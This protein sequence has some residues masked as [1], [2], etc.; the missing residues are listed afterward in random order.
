MRSPV[1][2]RRVRG[3]SMAPTLVDGDFVFAFRADGLARPPRV[4]DLV[5]LEPTPD[6]GA[7]SPIWRSLAARSMIKRIVAIAPEGYR[8]AGDSASSLSP[9]SFGWIARCDIIA[10][11][12]L[13]VPKT[14]TPILVRQSLSTSAGMVSPDSVQSTRK[15]N[16]MPR[17]ARTKA[18]ATSSTGTMPGQQ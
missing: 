7:R 10:R 18:A 5:V 4:G 9:E 17:V 14:G 1:L 2:I 11:V 6:V 16:L 13:R 8:V 12:C 15:F 3:V